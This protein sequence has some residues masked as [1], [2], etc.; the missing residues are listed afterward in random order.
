MTNLVANGA[1]K[2]P[3]EDVPVQKERPGIGQTPDVFILDQLE[4]HTQKRPLSKFDSKNQQKRGFI[5]VVRS[6]HFEKNPS[7]FL[8]SLIDLIFKTSMTL[9]CDKGIYP[10]PFNKRS[11]TK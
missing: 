7:S 8:A 1:G 2:N 3:T 5:R 10:L 4:R 9:Y 6:Q 11:K